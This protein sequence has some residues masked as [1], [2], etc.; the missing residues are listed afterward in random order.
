M[1][2][3]KKSVFLP[4]TRYVLIKFGAPRPTTKLIQNCEPVKPRP[5]IAA[6]QKT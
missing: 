5:S 6:A 3:W 4:W 2:S 1:I